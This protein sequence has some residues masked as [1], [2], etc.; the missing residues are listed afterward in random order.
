MGGGLELPIPLTPYCLSCRNMKLNLRCGGLGWNRDWSEKL[1]SVT[2]PFRVPSCLCEEGW[3]GALPLASGQALLDPVGW[4]Y[5]SSVG[6]N[7]GVLPP[8]FGEADAWGHKHCSVQARCTSGGLSVS[9]AGSWLT[10]TGFKNSCLWGV[11][12]KMLLDFNFVHA[13]SMLYGFWQVI[14]WPRLPAPSMNG[15]L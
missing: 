8:G 14:V 10:K 2:A 13:K 15:L 11:Q 5:P 4:R 6:Q 7:V 9:W 12:G 3:G 1:S